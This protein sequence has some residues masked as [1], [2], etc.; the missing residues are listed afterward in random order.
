MKIAIMGTGAMACL[1]GGRLMQ[2]GHEV[3]LVS[4]WKEHVEK[5]QKDGLT[6]QR[7]ADVF[8]VPIRVTQNP[9]D[10]IDNGVHPELVLI[11]SKG[12]QT[13]ATIK[14]AL[15]VIGPETCVL[16]LQNGIGNAD[17]IAEYVPHDRVFFGSASVA[18]DLVAL[19]HVKDTTNRNRS[20]LISIMPYSRVMDE[21]GEQLGRLFNGIGYET[22]VSLGA[23]KSIWTKLCVNCCANS[24]GAITR[25]SNYI[26]SNDRYG[27]QLLNKICAEVV[28]VAQAK[29]IDVDYEELRS[30]VHL[31]LHNQHHYISM[32]QDVYNK[33]PIEVDTINGAVV[34][35]AK[36]LGIPTPVN[37]TLV[38]LLKTIAGNYDNMW[39]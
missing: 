28:A 1:F 16:T 17:I 27:F 11:S 36:K 25:L 22:D 26:Y 34:R 31:T 33:R 12:M 6:I 21:R 35:E 37:E 38:L 30:F 13:R 14:K 20:P 19:G 3:W 23:E 7:E 39:M 5:I 2:S 29:G 32:L 9:A 8:Q 15:P 24:T 18:S 4:G 10:V